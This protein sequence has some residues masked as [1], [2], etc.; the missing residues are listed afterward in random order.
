MFKSSHWSGNTITTSEGG[1]E[2][3]L[4]GLPGLETSTSQQVRFGLSAR[5]IILFHGLFEG[6]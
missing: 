4:Y 1:L 6:F 5:G 2:L 3:G